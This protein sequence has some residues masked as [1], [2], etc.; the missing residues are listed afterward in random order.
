MLEVGPVAVVG[1][2]IE[3]SVAEEDRVVADTGAVE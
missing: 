3:G 2:N 1:G